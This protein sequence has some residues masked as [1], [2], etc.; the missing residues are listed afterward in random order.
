[1]FE[2]HGPDSPARRLRT[3][4]RAG[5]A[6]GSPAFAPDGRRIVFTGANDRGTTDAYVMRLDGAGARVI[7]YD[8]SHPTWSS[9]N[10][11]AYVREGNIH[12]ADPNG[13]HRRFVTSG[14][15][16][17]WSPNGRRLVLIRPSPRLTF[18]GSTGRIYVVNAG[19]G[20]LRRVGSSAYLSNPTW[21][22]NG[23]WLAFD[24]FDLPV[25]KRR[26][27]GRP[28]TREIALAPVAVFAEHQLVRQGHPH[29]R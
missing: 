25:R 20:G 1:V 17:D 29:G 16:P 18:A 28:I 6:D 19:G 13:R 24:G 21:S 5:P 26:L 10:E 8:A 7:V 9:R 14:V 11:I 2:S 23:R 4:D 22:P 15:A 27:T 3:L 12:R